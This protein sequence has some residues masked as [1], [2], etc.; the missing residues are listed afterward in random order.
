MNTKKLRFAAFLFVLIIVVAWF[1]AWE[2]NPNLI[3]NIR[4]TN[5]VAGIFI[6]LGMVSLHYILFLRDRNEED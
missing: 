6:A 4:P 5:I 3:Q 1:S 2:E